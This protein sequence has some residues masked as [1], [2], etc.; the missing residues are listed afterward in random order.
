M[1][2]TNGMNWKVNDKLASDDLKKYVQ[3]SL[4]QKEILDFVSRDYPIYKW[5]LRTLE[6]I[7][8]IMRYPYKR[9]AKL[10]RMNFVDLA[11]FLAIEPDT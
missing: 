6:Y 2:F 8:L 1:N 11:S 4:Q 9:L 5:S 3:Q 10:C 7:T